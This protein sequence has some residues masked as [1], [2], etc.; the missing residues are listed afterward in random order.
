MIP[1]YQV[2]ELLAVVF[3]E[4]RPCPEEP[5]QEESLEKMN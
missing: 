4:E 3:L 2:G 1:V 5:Y